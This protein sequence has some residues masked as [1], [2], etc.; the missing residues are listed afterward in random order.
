MKKKNLIVLK[1][2]TSNILGLIEVVLI[3]FEF[4]C[5]QIC[6]CNTTHKEEKNFDTPE[7]VEDFIYYIL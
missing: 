1:V 4:F 3:I 5:C 7:G 2:N 6:V